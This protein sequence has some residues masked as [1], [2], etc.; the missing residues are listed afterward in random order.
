MQAKVLFNNHIVNPHTTPVDVAVIRMEATN[1]YVIGN[2]IT[3]TDYTGGSYYFGKSD[4][5]RRANTSE[6]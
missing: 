5:T 2:S 4:V 1:S 3:G 6:K